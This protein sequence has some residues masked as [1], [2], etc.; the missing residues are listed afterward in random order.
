[1]TK[2]VIVAKVPDTYTGQQKKE[3]QKSIQLAVEETQVLVIPDDIDVMV[4][5]LEDT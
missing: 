2:S 4:I 3:L 5:H 1:M